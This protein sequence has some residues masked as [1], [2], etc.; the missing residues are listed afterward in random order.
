MGAVCCITR[1]PIQPAVAPKNAPAHGPRPKAITPGQSRFCAA[2]AT[3]DSHDHQGVWQ[4]VLTARRRRPTPPRQ[5]N[6]LVGLHP[7]RGIP[8]RAA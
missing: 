4:G 5:S 8:T 2:K 3:L 7:H 1:T 6:N